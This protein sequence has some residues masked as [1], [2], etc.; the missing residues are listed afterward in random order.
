MP[1]W[2]ILIDKVPVTGFWVGGVTLGFEVPAGLH[3]VE[4]TNEPPFFAVT[5]L[6]S[7]CLQLLI[8]WIGFRGWNRGST[9]E[10]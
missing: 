7:I 8:L 1:G 2:K 5:F 9:K 4:I 6:I 3:S 10:I